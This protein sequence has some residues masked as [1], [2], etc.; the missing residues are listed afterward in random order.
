MSIPS[1]ADVGLSRKAIHDAREVR[2][3][4]EADPGIVGFRPTTH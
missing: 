3:A 2:D 4:E 1:V